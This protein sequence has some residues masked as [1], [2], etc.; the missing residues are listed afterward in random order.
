M[1][2]PFDYDFDMDEMSVA[3]SYVMMAVASRPDSTIVPKKEE[4]E[5]EAKLGKEEQ[6]NERGEVAP[7]DDQAKI[8]AHHRKAAE[9]RFAQKESKERT[10]VCIEVKP[11]DVDQDLMELWKKITTSITQ[12]G[13]KWGESCTLVPVAFG[14]KKIRCTF[15]VGV[16]NSSDDIVEAIE[17]MEDEVQSV[18][19]TSMNV[20]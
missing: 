1:S 10:L 4:M 16:N 20:L 17:A 19:I 3:L 13:L 6:G 8:N 18:D 12:D 14:I 15:T 5:E 2:A 7:K 9:E 11:W